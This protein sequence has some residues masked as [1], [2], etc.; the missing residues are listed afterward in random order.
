M[1]KLKSSSLFAKA[2]K[3]PGQLHEDHWEDCTCCLCLFLGRKC[4]QL[5]S[6]FISFTKDFMDK[7]RKRAKR[8]RS[9]FQS[10]KV[11]IYSVAACLQIP[12]LQILSNKIIVK[13]Y[14]C[15]LM[16][17]RKKKKTMRI[18]ICIPTLHGE[19]FLHSHYSAVLHNSRIFVHH[20]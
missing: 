7:V 4:S 9:G 13:I 19:K 2:N 20:T 15:L 5:W 18:D 1:K 17:S 11:I 10:L 12:H 3:Q 14:I 16:Y 6:S 8:E